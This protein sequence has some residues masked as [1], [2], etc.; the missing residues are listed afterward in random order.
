MI[1][2]I[3]CKWCDAPKSSNFVQEILPKRILFSV[4]HDIGY[5]K[6][7]L[8]N[9]ME[10]REEIHPNRENIYESQKPWQL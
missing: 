2:I 7:K 5:K 10:N 1:L 4:M 6:L 9:T 3:S 8:R